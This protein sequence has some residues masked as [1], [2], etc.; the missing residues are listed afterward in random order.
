ME[1]FLEPVPNPASPERRAVGILG[2]EITVVPAPPKKASPDR[3][4]PKQAV[5]RETG[6]RGRNER[7]KFTAQQSDPAL[8]DNDS[9]LIY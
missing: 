7:R 5:A 9:D 2:S 4:R 1:E 8:A 6:S 3:P